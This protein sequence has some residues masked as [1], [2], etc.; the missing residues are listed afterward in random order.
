MEKIDQKLNNIFLSAAS[1]LFSSLF[2]TFSLWAFDTTDTCHTVPKFKRQMCFPPVCD[3]LR[4]VDSFVLAGSRSRFYI[5]AATS[6]HLHQRTPRGEKRVRWAFPACKVPFQSSF[7]DVSW[8]KSMDFSLLLFDSGEVSTREFWIFF[9][10][11]SNFEAKG[12]DWSE[13][14]AHREAPQ[15][16]RAQSA[17]SPSILE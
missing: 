12:W 7:Y 10:Q 6:T 9:W 3:F 1:F 2:I 14:E 8:C 17:G 16:F 4:Q 11:S 5:A 15:S 13:F